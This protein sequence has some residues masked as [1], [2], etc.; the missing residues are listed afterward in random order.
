MVGSAE[1]EGLQTTP[2][3]ARGGR[4]ES[5][6]DWKSLSDSI[7]HPSYQRKG[8]KR[9]KV[10]PW[11]TERILEDCLGIRD[12]GTVQGMLRVVTRSKQVN[13]RRAPTTKQ[14]PRHPTVER[15]LG[16]Y[17]LIPTAE[18]ICQNIGLPRKIP[19]IEVDVETLHPPQKLAGQQARE[20]ETIPP[21][22]LM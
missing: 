12:K 15:P 17:N 6:R 13:R 22:L 18:E 8:W 1:G 3:L 4:P 9:V 2:S 10:V 21:C 5:W 19:G 7:H 11:M 20:W 16:P 14:V